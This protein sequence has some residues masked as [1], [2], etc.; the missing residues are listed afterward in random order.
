MGDREKVS[1]HLHAGW[2]SSNT[3]HYSPQVTEHVRL[4][5]ITFRCPGCH[6]MGQFSVGVELKFDLLGH[7]HKGP[8]FCVNSVKERFGVKHSK[9]D[10]DATPRIRHE[11]VRAPKP[12]GR[13]SR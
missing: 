9:R 13:S 5:H 4:P 8:K 10:A 1:T 6:V 2:L 11:T 7:H 12:A 3:D